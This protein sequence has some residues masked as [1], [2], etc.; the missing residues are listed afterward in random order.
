MKVLSANQLKQISINILKAFGAS[1][2]EGEIVA[3][4]LVKA[5]LRGVDSH[6][7]I[8]LP[9][10]INRIK[11]KTII[12]GAPFKI[13]RETTSTALVDGGSGFGQVVAVK[14]IKLA[15]EKARRTGVGAIS[16]SNTNH[17]GMAAYYALIALQN[18]MASIITSNT[19]PWVV[20]WGGRVPMLGTNPICIAIPS[21]QDIPII[22]D[23]AT[24]ATARG[25]IEEA[26]K[27]GKP[28]PGGWAVDENG[29]PTTDP[30][31]AL[32]GALLPF[33]GPKG[34]CLS[35]IIDILSGCLAGAAYGKNV[36]S[37]YPEDHRCNIGQFFLAIDVNAF[38][39]IKEFKDA[40]DKAVHEIKLCPT[41]PGY[42]EILVPGEIEHRIE[43]KR[44]KE[45]IPLTDEVWRQIEK[46]SEETNVKIDL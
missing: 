38:I 18:D 2:V 45:G 29:R 24:S 46:I 39:P 32:K 41:S 36:I 16:V 26:A 22:L 8:R 42:S 20:P 21:G 33:G 23:M 5:N 14:A 7:V 11:N 30:I 4:S 3:D 27:E 43:L 34:Y 35:F 15:I 31:A 9:V 19:S 25:K 1:K 6:G 44:L 40:V 13:V 37:L 12:P 28:I 17:F 10:Y